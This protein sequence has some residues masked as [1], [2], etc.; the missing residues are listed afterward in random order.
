MFDLSVFPIGGTECVLL[1]RDGQIRLVL[2]NEQLSLSRAGRLSAALQSALEEHH[3]TAEKRI[4]EQ[5]T[6]F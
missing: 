2:D 3:R 6:P 4:T 1:H 5:E